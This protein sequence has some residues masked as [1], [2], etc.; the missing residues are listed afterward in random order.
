MS[1]QERIGKAVLWGVV[2][3]LLARIMV[4][5]EPQG[6]LTSTWIWGMILTQII[7]GLVIGL[8]HWDKPWYIRGP[9]LGAGVNLFLGIIFVLSGYGWGFGLIQT[10]CIGAVAGLLLEI[11]LNPNLRRLRSAIN[12]G[13]FF[14]ILTWLLITGISNEITDVGVRAILIYGALLGLIVGVVRWEFPWWIKGVLFGAALNGLLGFIM[15]LGSAELFPEIGFG[16]I[17]GFWMMMISGMVFG[18]GIELALK[19]WEKL[20]KKAQPQTSR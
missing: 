15:K 12:W 18:F 14:G 11:W 10:L 2:F 7:L 20:M 1:Q 13:F 19:H 9:A 4:L 16:W 3:G 17:Y 8:L 6:S 5:F